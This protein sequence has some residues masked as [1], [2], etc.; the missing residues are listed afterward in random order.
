VLP[1]V[2]VG[3]GGFIG[4]AGR[5]LLGQGVEALSFGNLKFSIATL[6]VNLLGSFLI[7]LLSQL[8]VLS[9]SD[10]G[11]VRLFL[12][13]GI[14]GGFTTFSAFSLETM[15]L[16]KQEA[17]FLAGINIVLQVVVGLL[18]VF[19]GNLVAKIVA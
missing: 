1:I 14:L 2:Y 16:L 7:G 9:N 19:S 13:T 12:V 3:L 10:M 17:F 6:I 15:T 8:S 4:S 18:A 11:G 5:Y